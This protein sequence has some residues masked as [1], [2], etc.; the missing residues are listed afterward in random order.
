[1]LADFSMGLVSAVVASESRCRA[2]VRVGA[3][4]ALGDILRGDRQHILLDAHRDFL[5]GDRP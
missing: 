2:V 5:P 3:E 1:M 4:V